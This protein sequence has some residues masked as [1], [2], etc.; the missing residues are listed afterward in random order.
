MLQ[1]KLNEQ[2]RSLLAETLDSSLST[3]SDEIAH[4][5]TREY[6]EYLVARREQLNRIRTLLH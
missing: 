1:I 4:T 6:R 5:D 2:E 3:L